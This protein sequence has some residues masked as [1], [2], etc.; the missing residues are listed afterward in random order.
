M[1]KNTGALGIAPLDDVTT[2]I[3]C[4]IMEMTPEERKKL[5]ELWKEVTSQDG[6]GIET[7]IAEKTE[8]LRCE[9]G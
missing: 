8:I 5:L 1:E 9:T 3:L 2:E 6:R 4:A 7:G